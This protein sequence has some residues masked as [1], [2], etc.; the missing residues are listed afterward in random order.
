MGGSSSQWSSDHYARYSRSRENNL[1]VAEGG[2]V[3]HDFFRPRAPR[4]TEQRLWDQNLSSWE[5]LE[6][7]W[8]VQ[9]VLEILTLESKRSTKDVN[10]ATT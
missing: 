7:A 10:E 8:P 1:P 4:G 3:V 5:T 2:I 9:G 6:V